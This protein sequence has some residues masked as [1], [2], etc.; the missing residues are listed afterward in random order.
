MPPTYV[1][2]DLWDELPRADVILVTTNA[3]LNAKNELI[4]GRGAALEA[5]QRYPRLPYWLG[6]ELLKRN[7]VGKLYGIMGIGRQNDSN[8]L[9][10]AFQVKCHWRDDARLEI[11]AFS[12][13][14]LMEIAAVYQRIAL[15]CPAIGNRRLAARDVVSIL[16]PLPSHVYI[17]TKEPLCS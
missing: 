13:G 8:A 7:A 14:Q 11:V 15:N 4:M 1:V 3:T 16:S 5:A 9:I 2:G 17:Y 6:K 12:A 10:G